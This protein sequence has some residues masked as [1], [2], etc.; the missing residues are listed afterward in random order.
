MN[1]L[2]VDLEM[3]GLDV[4]KERIIEFAGIITDMNFQEQT[5]YHSIVYQEQI[6]IDGMDQWNTQH[7]GASGLIALIP[8]GKKQEDVEQEVLQ[9][10]HPFFDKDNPAILCGNS[11]HQDRKFI[12]HYMPNLSQKLHYRLLDTTAYK[13][14]FENKYSKKL[15]KKESHRALEDIRESIEELKFY[16][17]FIKV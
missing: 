10:M 2:W 5:K 13:I 12:D 16:L 4:E 11:I 1:L 3:T 7:H 15:D 8:T 6:F 9:W 17:S 14:I